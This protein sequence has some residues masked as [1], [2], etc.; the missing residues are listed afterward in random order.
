MTAHRPRPGRAIGHA[1]RTLPECAS[2]NDLAADLPAGEAVVAESQSAGRGQ[3]G[4]GWDAPPGSALLLSV[5]CG[6]LG[7]AA[8]ALT[9]WATVAV[10][11][12]VQAL[13]GLRPAIKWPNDLLV[14]D[15]KI[16]G[17][18]V[19]R[20]RQV[21]VGVGL[22]LAR[23]RDEF[24]AA[25]L[26]GAGS[27]W[28][29]SGVRVAASDAAEAVLDALDAWRPT[30]ATLPELEAAWVTRL[31]LGSG[32]EVSGE[33]ADGNPFAGRVERVGFAG[34][35]LAGRTPIPLELVRRFRPTR[36][37]PSE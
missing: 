15:R 19:E 37:R 23:T 11:E 8:P 13:S 4:R 30:P 3:Y 22:N 34:L 1:V 35:A 31:G 10:A 5:A 17:I 26:P 21:V 16:C 27:L 20:G 32:G 14:N 2:T 18:L 24:A 7:H 25:G 28:S 36:H 12:A 9:A 29:E 33:L 6:P